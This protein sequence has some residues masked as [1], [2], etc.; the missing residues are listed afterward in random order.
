MGKKISSESTEKILQLFND[1]Q[2]SISEISK[3]LHISRPTIYSVLEKY[4]TP[5]IEEKNKKRESENI[6]NLLSL[7]LLYFCTDCDL[8]AKMLVPE[9]KTVGCK[10]III[11]KKMTLIIQ[12]NKIVEIFKKTGL[13]CELHFA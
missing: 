12:K 2:K 11:P 8:L 3:V 6:L 9:I 5:D 1:Y 7:R 4:R 10:K 13:E